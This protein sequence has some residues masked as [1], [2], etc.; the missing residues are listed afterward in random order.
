M[1]RIDM[2]VFL[3]TW[4]VDPFAHTVWDIDE[5]IRVEDVDRAILTGTYLLASEPCDA[6]ATREQHAQRVAWLVVHG[7]ADPVEIDVGIPS[8]GF[9]PSWPITDGNHR[10]AAAIYRGDFT[11][12]A[13]CSGSTDYI[14]EFIASP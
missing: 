11:I 3:E 4:D 2:T 8:L 7:W 13:E 9:T 6:S 1:E 12:M 10:F 5:P 14:S